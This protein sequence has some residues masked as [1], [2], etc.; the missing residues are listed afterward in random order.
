LGGERSHLVC[1]VFLE[2]HY[3]VLESL[4]RFMDLGL[5]NQRQREGGGRAEVFHLLPLEFGNLILEA[6]GQFG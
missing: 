5:D 6:V 2:E 4:V 3:L 1:E